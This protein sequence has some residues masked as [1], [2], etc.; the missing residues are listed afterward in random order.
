MVMGKRQPRA[1][2]RV[3]DRSGAIRVPRRW[4]QS[5]SGRISSQRTAPLLS[6]SKEIASDSP[7]RLPFGLGLS[8]SDM[9]LRMY[10]SDVPQRNAKA[11]CSSVEP[12][13]LRYDFRASITPT[14]P[15]GNGKSIPGVHLPL[16]NDAY[17]VSSMEDKVFE[18]RRQR[19]LA[20]IR[21]VG[22]QAKLASKVSVIR[23]KTMDPSY[24]SRLVAKPGKDGRKAITGDM[25]ADLEKAGGKEP[26]W[27]SHDDA[28]SAKPSRF[29]P[30]WPFTIP[31]ETIES[32]SDDMRGEI[33]REFTKL[34]VAA[35]MKRA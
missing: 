10:D 5:T 3:V 14:L 25:A 30:R 23:K 29:D 22:G 2:L 9:T 17:P 4:R 8:L 21:E 20:L 15:A 24:I 35:L 32:M 16:G 26:G 11:S 6:F 7:N 31:R 33:D 18:I 28:A 19:L 1:T 27:L 12:R 34:V 13:D